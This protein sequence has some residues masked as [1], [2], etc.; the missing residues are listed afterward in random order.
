MAAA[1]AVTA[2]GLERS[3][4]GAVPTRVAAA[5]V[6]GGAGPMAAASQ[7]T[8]RRG[9]VRDETLVGVRVRVRFRVRFRVRVRV[10]VRVCDLG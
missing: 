3:A 2:A 7:R 9:V 8:P 5:Y 4:P 6:L 1:S 10:R